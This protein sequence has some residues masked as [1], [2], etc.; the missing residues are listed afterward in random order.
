MG[1]GGGLF[2]WLEGRTHEKSTYVYGVWAGPVAM[3]SLFGSRWAHARS[4]FLSFE[5]LF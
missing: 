1:W 4:L 5:P 2:I 3:L